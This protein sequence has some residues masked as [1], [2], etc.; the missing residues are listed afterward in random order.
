MSKGTTDLTKQ[1][2]E[3]LENF[4]KFTLIEDKKKS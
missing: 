1:E 4:D 2:K 3:L